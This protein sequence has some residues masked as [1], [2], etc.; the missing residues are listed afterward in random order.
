MAISVLLELRQPETGKTSPEEARP[1][2][3]GFVEWLEDFLMQLQENLD[4]VDQYGNPLFEREQIGFMSEALT[5]IRHDK[6]FEHLQASVAEADIGALWRHGLYGS[7]LRWKLFNIN[8]SFRRFIE[9]HSAE[10][11]DRLL[12]SIDALLESLLG[13]VPG[14]S[15]IKELKEA[16][17]NSIALSTE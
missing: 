9:G 10:L 2:L 17:Q 11:L 12:S 6:H 16:I 5:E 14:G 4:E 15:A 3:R 7:Q 13:A 1:Y 8:F